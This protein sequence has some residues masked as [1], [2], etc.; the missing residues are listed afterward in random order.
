MTSFY[1]GSTCVPR[2]GA[3]GFS[4]SACSWLERRRPDARAAKLGAPP[5]GR[6]LPGTGSTLMTCSA[7]ARGCERFEQKDVEL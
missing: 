7:V 2:R 5:S 4:C 1:A 6:N 3:Y